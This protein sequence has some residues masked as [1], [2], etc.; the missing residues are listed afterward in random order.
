M[1]ADCDFSGIVCGSDNH[2][3]S[4]A[5]D[6]DH[7]VR[8]RY[9]YGFIAQEVE[10]V[11]PELVRKTDHYALNYD[12][13]TAINTAAIKELLE[14]VERLEEENRRLRKELEGLKGR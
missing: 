13:M 4:D 8:G 11:L 12:H 9:D 5:K 3:N 10:Q 1:G 2:P 6:L 14:R 7:A